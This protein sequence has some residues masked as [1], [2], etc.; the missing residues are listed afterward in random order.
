MKPIFNTYGRYPEGWLLHAPRN[1]DRHYNARPFLYRN[2]ADTIASEVLYVPGAGKKDHT[3]S[4]RLLSMGVELRM[5]GH[6]REGIVTVADIGEL[7][8]EWIYNGREWGSHSKRI[9]THL[10][11]EGR[12]NK[13]L[14]FFVRSFI[15]R[16]VPCIRLGVD[17]TLLQW[18]NAK[19]PTIRPAIEELMADAIERF[20]RIA[21]MYLIRGYSLANRLY[22]VHMASPG[23]RHAIFNAVSSKVSVALLTAARLNDPV[24]VIRVIRATSGIQLFLLERE[25][26][27]D[28]RYNLKCLRSKAVYQY[29]V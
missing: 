2:T 13:G 27:V 25:A 11:P 3:I 17:A 6:E 10:N 16:N 18:V 28:C 8:A 15:E 20:K 1:L 7:F 29:E 5:R 22:D 21:S 4:E 23:L 19:H 9:E 26:A 24:L 14:R 12:S